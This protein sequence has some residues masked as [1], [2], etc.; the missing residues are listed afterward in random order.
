[1]IISIVVGNEIRYKYHLV[2]TIETQ[3]LL[4]LILSLRSLEVGDID[5]GLSVRPLTVSP[6]IT[7]SVCRAHK[8]LLFQKC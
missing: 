7:F 2:A 8:Y 4:K 6:S 1:M 3:P 5:L